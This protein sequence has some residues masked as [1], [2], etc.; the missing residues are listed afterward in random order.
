MNVHTFNS[1]KQPN[2]IIISTTK[3]HSRSLIECKT[4]VKNAITLKV[5]RYFVMFGWQTLVP[6]LFLYI[7]YKGPSIIIIKGQTTLTT[8]FPNGW[9]VPITTF[10]PNFVG[11]PKPS[12]LRKLPMW[13][14]P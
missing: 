9:Q 4:N 10:N 13:V 2:E 8:N 6:Y 5:N 11:P 3:A 1:P 7:C 14:P 12:K